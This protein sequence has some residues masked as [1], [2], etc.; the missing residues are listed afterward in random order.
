LDS[1]GVEAASTELQYSD[2]NIYDSAIPK[3]LTSTYPEMTALFGGK[4]QSGSSVSTITSSGGTK[5]T[6]FAKDNNWGKDLYDDLVEPTLK[7]PF[8][9]ETWRRSPFLPS[10]CTSQYN[11]LNVASISIGS[12]QFSYTQDHSKWGV[13]MKGSWVCVGGINRM[14][15][16][17]TRGGGTLCVSNNAFWKALSGVVASTEPCATKAVKSVSSSRGE[18]NNDSTDNG[19]ETAQPEGPDNET[20]APVEHHRHGGPQHH[21]RGKG[22]HGDDRHHQRQHGGHGQDKNHHGNGNQHRGWPHPGK[23]HDQGGH[24]RPEHGGNN[25]HGEHGAHGE[26]GGHH[27]D[28][29]HGGHGEQHGRHHGGHHNGGGGGAPRHGFLQKVH[30]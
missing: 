6:S 19:D 30:N 16:Q 9:W 12:I 24:N 11:T 27:N 28:N 26:H 4:R 17:R 14:Q 20:P 22:H 7:M 23:H 13:S 3:S 8:E 5:F 29:K 21:F 25:K 1:D 15:S 2:P 10:L 18:D